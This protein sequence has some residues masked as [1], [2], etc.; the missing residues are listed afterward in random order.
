[1][2]R[3]GGDIDFILLICFRMLLGDKARATMA[4]FS[5]SGAI[6]PLGSSSLGMVGPFLLTIQK[7]Y[8]GVKGK[9][10]H[11]LSYSSFTILGLDKR[12]TVLHLK[13]GILT[14]VHETFHFLLVSSI[15]DCGVKECFFGFFNLRFLPLIKFIFVNLKINPL[16]LE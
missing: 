12:S 13:D 5:F 16:N 9:I 4:I 15:T 1:M 2:T 8:G 10:S 14:K 6:M 11:Y 7:T 3:S